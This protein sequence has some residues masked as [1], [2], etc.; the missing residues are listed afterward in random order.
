MIEGQNDLDAAEQALRGAYRLIG[1]KVG[2]FA[3]RKTPDVTNTIVHIMPKGRRVE[4]GWFK[5]ATWGNKSEDM[6]D[7]LDFD[8][9]NIGPSL[10]EVFV[11]GEALA[12]TPRKI[13]ELLFHQYVHQVAGVESTSTY[14]GNDYM[15]TAKALGV[16][17]V[18]RHP[19]QGWVGFEHM[20]TLDEV[21]GSVAASLDA[22]AF[23]LYRHPETTKVGSGKMR[24]WKCQ[25]KRGPSVYTGA[26]L[27][28]TC[29]ECNHPF[30]YAHKDLMGQELRR[31]IHDRG[32]HM[33][34]CVNKAEVGGNYVA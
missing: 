11:A 32:E 22:K 8:E 28:A 2:E 23:D 14:H 15:Q 18:T 1:E 29:R 27:H 30:A 26:I 16:F 6:V 33:I 31:K 20:Q 9:G 19:T 7:A 21:L 34:D 25:C 13:V 3:V 5:M 12:G 24:L 4:S 17:E 10:D